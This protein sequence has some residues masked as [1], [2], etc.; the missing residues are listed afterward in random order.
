VTPNEPD[1]LETHVRRFDAS[2][3]LTAQ[4]REELQARP[5]PVS[6][7]TLA[8]TLGAPVGAVDA[9]LTALAALGEAQPSGLDNTWQAA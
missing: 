3:L 4:V 9:A 6:A 8:E 5:E 1:V 7:F 2:T